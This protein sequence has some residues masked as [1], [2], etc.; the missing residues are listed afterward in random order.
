[1]L[2]K[3]RETPEWK[4]YVE[5][6]AQTN[7]FLTHGDFQSFLSSDEARARQVFEKEGWLVR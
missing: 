4:D 1:V 3:A 6:T 2:N 5:R 7:K